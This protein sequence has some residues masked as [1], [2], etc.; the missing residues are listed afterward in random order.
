[1][2]HK[3]DWQQFDISGPISYHHLLLL[4]KN[5]KQK[6]PITQSRTLY[7]QKKN[8]IIISSWPAAVLPLSVFFRLG[9]DL[10]SLSLT[11]VGC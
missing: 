2:A 3:D 10:L 1:M 9:L 4:C 6:A 8:L 5:P 11:H 7:E